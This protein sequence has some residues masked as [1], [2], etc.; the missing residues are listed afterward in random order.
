MSLMYKI[1]LKVHHSLLYYLILVKASLCVEWSIFKVPVI[2]YRK[3]S[4]IRRIKS[5]NLNVPRLVLQL[6]LL[7]PV[8]PGVKSRMKM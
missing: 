3:I 8:K 1:V 4:D 5:P 7:N 2:I 6:S